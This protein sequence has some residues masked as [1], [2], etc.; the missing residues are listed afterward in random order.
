MFSSHRFARTSPWSSVTSLTSR[1]VFERN[2]P[3]DQSCPFSLRNAKW[4]G[5]NYDKNKEKMAIYFA[6]DNQFLYDMKKKRKERKVN[7]R[8]IYT[9]VCAICSGGGNKGNISFYRWND[10]RQIWLTN[11]QTK[12]YTTKIYN[13]E[14]TKT[15]QE[16]KLKTQDVLRVMVK[17]NYAVP[18]ISENIV[19]SCMMNYVIW[20]FSVLPKMCIFMK[21]HIWQ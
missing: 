6:T 5:G 14:N 4:R 18:S 9:A 10:Y 1:P 12:R 19:T 2:S 15:K 7:A 16:T 3:P 21:N 8:S 20:A 11:K 17:W 13:T